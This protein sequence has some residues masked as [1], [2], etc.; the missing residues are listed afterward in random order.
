MKTSALA[1]IAM[2]AVLLVV[3]LFPLMLIFGLVSERAGRRNEAA[4]EVSAQWGD[5]QTISGPILSVDFRTI[6]GTGVDGKPLY[7]TDRAVFLPVALRVDSDVMPETR[8]RG[9]FEVIVYRSR[10]KVSGR[11][12]SPEFSRWRVDPDNVL[13]AT[14]TL[15]IGVSDP[16]G[17]TGPI[18]LSWNGGA[19]SLVPG[20]PD[21]GLSLRGISAAVPLPETGDLTFDLTLE[22][23]GT[24]E[25]RF[26]PAGNDTFIAMR[27][28]WPHPSFVGAPLPHQRTISDRGFTAEWN[29]PYYGRSFATSWSVNTINR[30]QLRAATDASAFGVSLVR[31]VDIYQQAERA[32][33]YAV[34]FIV[35]TFVIAFLWEIIHGVP[36]HPV[37]YIFIGF[38]LC[39]FYLLLLALSE[40]IGFDVAY[41]VAAAANVA[42]IA[43]YWSWV[44]HGGSRHGLL[45]AGA[46]TGLYGYLYL[47]LRQE[48]H[49]LLGGAIGLFVM[50]ALVMYLTRRIDWYT[51]T[52]GR[53][54]SGS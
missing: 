39:V 43:W 35:L 24:R 37:Q 7:V 4:R 51:L 6:S 18:A 50:L 8:R 54:E 44:I 5:A 14:G 17:I 36:V 20:T 48:D 12:A 41:V 38:A 27:S 2:M 52:I 13:R 30:E 29:V 34:L 15:S 11:F 31:P 26:L 21:V 53:E 16:R 42:L 22:T 1:R 23:N 49:A 3:L 32:V 10:L 9:I 25:L 19:R 28:S 40:H 46:L 33:K 47:L 45:M